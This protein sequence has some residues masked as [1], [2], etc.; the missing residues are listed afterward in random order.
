MNP[1]EECITK[2]GGVSATGRKIGVSK[3]LVS[4]WKNGHRPVPAHR[5]KQLCKEAG[6][7]FKVCAWYPELCEEN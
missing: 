2:L 3:Q 5:A 4:Q 7:P 6:M 1:V